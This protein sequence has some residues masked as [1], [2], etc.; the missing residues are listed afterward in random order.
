M[1]TA[2]F[3]RSFFLCA[4]ILF[5]THTQAQTNRNLLLQAATEQ[6]LNSYLQPNNKWVKYPVYTDRSGWDKYTGFVKDSL[7]SNG[8]K[9]LNYQWKTVP[10][11]AYLD[12]ERTGTR[13]TM[14]APLNSNV[15]ALSSLLIAELAE[16]KGRFMD[17]V[18]DGVWAIC[19]HSSWTLSAH[20][21]VQK[22]RRSL[23]DFR[24][25]II[26][27][28]SGDIGSLLSWA[29]YLFKDE[30]NK[31]DPVIAA[32]VKKQV[33][34]RIVIPYLQRDNY[35][36]QAFNAKPGATI[37]NWNVWCNA[38]VL[39]CMLLVADDSV[40]TAG[41]YKTMRSVD[42]FLN[43]VKEDGAC[44]EGPSYWGHAAGKLYD[45]LQV[46]NE[47][48]GGKINIFNYPMVKNM[49][50]Y[51]SRSYVG[52]GWVVN[53]A[54]AS[55]K[56][57]GE[58]GLVYRFGQAVNSNEMKAYAAYLAQKE[59]AR[60]FI[61]EGRDFYRTIENIQTYTQ[62]KQTTP[63]L[64]AAPYTWYPQTEFCYIRNNNFFF[65]A[66]GGFNNESHNHNDVG[67]FSLYY[68]N[69]PFIIDVGVGTYT[70]ETFSSRRYSIWTMQSNYH[71][72][73]LINGKAQPFGAQYKAQQARFDNKKHTFSLDITQA[74][75]KEAGIKKWSRQFSLQANGL[76][77]TEE[78]ELSKAD[79]ATAFHFMS[80]AKPVI[81]PNGQVILQ[82]Q[83]E[84]ITISYNV[85][86]LTATYETIPVTDTRL[87]NVWGSEVYRI[88]LTA[89]ENK[90]KQQYKIMITGK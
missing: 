48:S 63:A 42:K 16:G 84:T 85:K 76:T 74:Y 37:N 72:V 13:T 49:G 66:K 24:E 69:I 64:S 50:E 57:G 10:A 47:A 58:A 33:T 6:Q 62:V 40:R 2:L 20:Q 77:I 52:N 38:N 45:Y 15:N 46:L 79:S 56:G 27:L 75:P 26:D 11:T 88:V 73:P 81:E 31:V 55:A 34:D 53:F 18:I 9:F 36:W 5:F 17:Q 12:Y 23:P 90:L 82:K 59:T 4:G 39:V 61:N 60:E 67:S 71:N 1:F 35:W 28:V 22:T 89:K 8:V 7:I 3:F 87:S 30:W 51:I 43:H 29:L 68:K 70:K 14:E 65:A 44:E 19:E 21:V 54:D 80:W 83:N 86:A 25:E 78:G 41:V 32:K